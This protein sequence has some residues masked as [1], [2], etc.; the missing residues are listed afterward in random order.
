ML[1]VWL[2][3]LVGKSIHEIEHKDES[4]NEEAVHF[5]DKH[6]SCEICNFLIAPSLTPPA[7]F[8]EFNVLLASTMEPIQIIN[9]NVVSLIKY[10]FLLRGPPVI[11]QLKAINQ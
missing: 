4:C 5:C 11:Y 2:A 1:L 3:P 10:T 9:F 7:C 8:V 6:H